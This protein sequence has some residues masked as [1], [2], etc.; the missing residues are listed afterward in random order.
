MTYLF[1]LVRRLAV[2]RHWGMLLA[3]ALLAGCAG[4]T[5]SPEGEAL[6]SPSTADSLQIFPRTV[7]LELDQ[8]IR[9]R[10]QPRHPGGEAV[11]TH[12]AWRATGGTIN[13]DGSFSAAAAGTYQVFARG[14]GWRQSEP[15]IVRVVPPQPTIARIVIAPDPLV[16]EAGASHHFTATAYLPNGSTAPLGIRWRA[17]GGEVDGAGNYTADSTAGHYRL[18]AS[19][20]AGT[21]ADTVA[22]TIVPPS[23]DMPP[24]PVPVS[25]D[26]GAPEGTGP[27]PPAPAG[28]AHRRVVLRPAKVSLAAGKRQQFRSFG[29]TAGGDSIAVGVTYKVT[30][31]TITR[32]GLYTAGQKPGS[33]KIIASA[34]G[35][36]D[37]AIITLVPAPT[38]TPTPTPAPTPAPTP[39]PAPGPGPVYTGKVG[40][41]FGTF[42][43]WEG[44]TVRTNAADFS[45]SIGS[46]DASDIVRRIAAARATG[47]RL[48]L[49][50]TGGSHTNYKTN[51]VFDMNKWTA[52]MNQYNTPAI[53]AAVAAAV[54]DGTVLGNS[55]MDEPQNT[56]TDNSWGP[57]GTLTKARV[58]EM[59]AYVKNMFPTLPVGV[60]HDHNAFQPSQSYKSCDYIVS[61]Y[62]WAKTKGDVIKFRDEALALGRRDGIAIAFS[63]NI[64]DGGLPAQDAGGCTIPQTGGPGTYGRNC[65]MTPQQVR[66]WGSVLGQAGCAL[67]MWRY[68]ASYMANPENVKAFQDVAAALAKAPATGCRRR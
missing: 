26:P 39:S 51:G 29:R 15:S 1:K 23:I 27:T 48:F 21:V 50:M 30:G 43:A 41:P 45:L 18:M 58:D 16:L 62:R 8:E 19:N 54:A 14:S 3:L 13:P 32:G 37:T 10:A 46:T 49:A 2:S 64:L 35:I 52:R 63:L 57:A 56:S 67:T 24:T 68:D 34:A 31:G 20:T 55:V 4:D 9:F 53:K 22:V 42:G 47:H 44:T 6:R 25:P 12:V 60:V 61:Q 40:V 33:Y 66:E 65:R 28:V 59:C 36:A 17:T 11:N 7:T 38:P 5:T